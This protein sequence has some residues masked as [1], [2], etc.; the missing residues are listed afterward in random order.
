MNL[1][2]ISDSL[3]KARLG[4]EELGLLERRDKRAISALYLSSAFG[5]GFGVGCLLQGYYMAVPFTIVSCL[6]PIA[7]LAHHVAMGK[8]KITDPQ[9]G[10]AYEVPT[11]DVFAIKPNEHLDFTRYPVWS[12]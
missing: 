10:V 5:V 6:T 1:E 2:S 12:H 7:G 8:R 11:K 4:N 3:D 9:S